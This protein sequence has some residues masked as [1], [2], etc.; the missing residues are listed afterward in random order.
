[1]VRCGL[2]GRAAATEENG[3]GSRFYRCWH[4][5]RGCGQPSRSVRGIERAA[6]LGLRLVGFD[7][8]LQKA[9]RQ[10]LRRGARPGPP[11]GAGRAPA[12]QA[13][14]LR[15]RRRKLLDLHYAGKI[16]ADLFAE[17]EASLTAQIQALRS[18]ATAAG[19]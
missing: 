12:Q 19:H 15:E 5:G 17:E 10:E 7:P 1:M 18:H 9:I 14:R 11:K 6:L 13:D 2:C 3:K 16:T 4:R 8:D